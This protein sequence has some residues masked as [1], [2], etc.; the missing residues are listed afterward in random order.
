[1]YLTGAVYNFCSTH[2]SLSLRDGRRQTPAM[3]AG[4][5]DL[6]WTVS[7]LLHYRVPP[8][9]WEPP[10]RRGRRSKALQALIDRWCPDHR[11]A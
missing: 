7:E 8:H 2:A 6:A 3:A 11:L 5:T 1:M 4:L 9:R 10:R